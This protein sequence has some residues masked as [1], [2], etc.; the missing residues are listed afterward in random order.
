MDL[1]SRYR[2]VIARHH[3]ARRAEGIAHPE[4]DVREV[5]AELLADLG[6]QTDHSSIAALAV[7]VDALCHPCWPAPGLA[8]M[9][10]CF[11][12]AGLRL[13]VISNAQA[14]TPLLF[15]A[16]T[17][18]NVEEWGFRKDLQAYSW[19]GREAKPSVRL[20]HRLAERLRG[21][22]GIEPEQAA[23][24][25]NDVRNDIAPANLAGFHTI[26][27][28]GDARSLR[29]R[30]DDPACGNVKPGRIIT[31]LDQLPLIISGR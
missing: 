19:E 15:P 17:G 6:I 29:W 13:G 25:G 22:Y 10:T 23:Y 1:A 24:I 31:A 26:L 5:W 9:L 14:H 7:E 16:L 12:E 11:H 27:F 8:A 21:T 30:R 18:R 28:A 3:A 2:D 20:F 4:V